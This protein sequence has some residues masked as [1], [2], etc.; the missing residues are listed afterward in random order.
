[1]KKLILLFLVS[2][3]FI[4]CKKATYNG[5]KLR[6]DSFI[7]LELVTENFVGNIYKDTYTGVL[8]RAWGQGVTPIMEADGTCLTWDE[9]TKRVDNN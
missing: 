4:S 9:W 5:K 7:N 2:L 3:M 1:M 8:Y 6:V